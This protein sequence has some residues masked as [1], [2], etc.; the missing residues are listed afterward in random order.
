MDAENIIIHMSL[1]HGNNDDM[2]G[3]PRLIMLCLKPYIVEQSYI[4]EY[5]LENHSSAYLERRLRQLQ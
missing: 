5:H 2:V 3:I 4:A 1:V